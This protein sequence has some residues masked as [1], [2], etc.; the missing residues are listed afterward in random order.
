LFFFVSPS[1]ISR[2]TNNSSREILLSTT[3]SFEELRLLTQGKEVRGRVL[4]DR[5]R[6]V[7]RGDTLKEVGAHLSQFN[8]QKLSWCITTSRLWQLSSFAA[9]RKTRVLVY[10]TRSEQQVRTKHKTPCPKLLVYCNA[11]KLSQTWYGDLINPKKIICANNSY[12]A[13]W[14]GNTLVEC[15]ARLAKHCRIQDLLWSSVYSVECD[16]CMLVLLPDILFS[17]RTLRKLKKTTVLSLAKNFNTEY[18]LRIATQLL[19]DKRINDKPMPA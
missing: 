19:T 1:V 6:F 9:R 11:I 8:K 13:V 17:E 3:F 7:L 10:S 18:Y 2:V 16:K 14:Q 5:V 15:L 12:Q 4:W